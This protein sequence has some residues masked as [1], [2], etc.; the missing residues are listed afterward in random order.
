MECTMQHGPKHSFGSMDEDVFI[1]CSKPNKIID[2]PPPPPKGSFQNMSHVDHT[3]GLV[4]L[5]RNEVSRLKDS[6]KV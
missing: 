6:S 5:T 1:K 4:K 2:P 3:T